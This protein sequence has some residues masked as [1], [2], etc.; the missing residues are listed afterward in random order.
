MFSQPPAALKDHHLQSIPRMITGCKAPGDV[1]AYVARHDAA[2]AGQ[3]EINLA[4]L[5]GPNI[6]WAQAVAK[7]E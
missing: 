2:G 6:R 1:E 4:G 7:K 3:G 5:A